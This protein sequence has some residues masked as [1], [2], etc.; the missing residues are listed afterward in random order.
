MGE[1]G[2]GEF[3]DLENVVEKFDELIDA[4]ANFCDLGGLRYRI[5][6]RPHVM[7]TT[8]R[9][10]DDIVELFEIRD[11]KGFGR[12]RVVLAAAVRHRLSA[13]GLIEWVRHINAEPFENLQRRN[14]DFGKKG[15]DVTRNEQS[16]PHSATSLSAFSAVT[17]RGKRAEDLLGSICP[18]RIELRA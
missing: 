7:G 10:R 11:E 5:E 12:R 18:R 14:T 4:A 16:H 15:V 8:A 6:M 13:A 17:G 1:F 9:W 2:P 3:A